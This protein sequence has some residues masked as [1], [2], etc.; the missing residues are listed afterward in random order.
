MSVSPVAPAATAEGDTVIV[1][2]PS[3]ATRTTGDPEVSAVTVPVL[4]G[5]SLVANVSLR[6]VPGAVTPEPPPLVSP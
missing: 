6:G 2:A 5:R 3:D 1:P 4:V